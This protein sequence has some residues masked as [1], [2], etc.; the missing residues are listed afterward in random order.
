MDK[1]CWRFFKKLFSNNKVEIDPDMK[2]LI[3]GLGNMHPDY[4]GTR[5]NVGFELVRSSCSKR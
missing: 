2:F 3:V 5:H 4:E 1:S